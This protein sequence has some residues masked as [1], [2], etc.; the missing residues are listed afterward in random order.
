MAKNMYG[1]KVDGAVVSTMADAAI[2]NTIASAVGGEVIIMTRQAAN[3]FT[4]AA[5]AAPV[6]PPR[7]ANLLADI[8]DLVKLELEGESDTCFNFT[9]RYDSHANVWYI[10]VKDLANG[11]PVW[12]LETGEKH[13]SIAHA[14][15]SKDMNCGTAY[16]MSKVKLSDD[17]RKSLFV[18][19]RNK[20]SISM[21][22]SANV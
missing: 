4:K 22:T 7:F 3:S 6:L 14:L 20:L 15:W 5:T 11:R 2:A 21:R 10:A 19:D 13:D 8:K 9:V 18:A 17:P 1:V 16:L 12:D